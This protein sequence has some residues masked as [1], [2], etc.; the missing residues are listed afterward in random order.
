M[1]IDA[2]R[3]ALIE[4]GRPDLASM[5]D[6]DPTHPEVGVIFGLGH[7]PP[8]DQFL[9]YKAGRICGRMTE[10]C[11]SCWVAKKWNLDEWP[12]RCEHGP[13]VGGAA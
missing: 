11:C 8:E 12:L 4:F 10:I 3:G 2:S 13:D 1:S 9:I 5:L 7:L 6:V